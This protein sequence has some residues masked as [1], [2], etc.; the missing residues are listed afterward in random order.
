MMRC[1][2]ECD[3]VRAPILRIHQTKRPASCFIEAGFRRSGAVYALAIAASIGPASASSTQG[4][5]VTSIT[6]A[7]CA[8]HWYIAFGSLLSEIAKPVPF[9]PCQR[10]SILTPSG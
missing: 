2:L 10:P 4:V 5:T 9:M 6:F 8:Y 3:E 7:H 1:V